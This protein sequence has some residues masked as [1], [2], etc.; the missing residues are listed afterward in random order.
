M[1]IH[2]RITKPSSRVTYE[3]PF[4]GNI[5]KGRKSSITSMF[6][7]QTWPECCIFSSGHIFDQIV[8]KGC[9]KP[10]DFIC[11]SS[12]CTFWGLNGF[13]ALYSGFTK[14]SPWQYGPEIESTVM[15]LTCHSFKPFLALLVSLHKVSI[16][17]KYNIISFFHEIM[18]VHFEFILQMVIKWLT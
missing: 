7:I 3:K 8:E 2:G 16:L 11:H 6:C 18:S 4:V 15:S 9:R 10:S 17:L 5:S 1:S 12:K 13:S 14:G